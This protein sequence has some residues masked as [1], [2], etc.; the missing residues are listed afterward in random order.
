MKKY[1]FPIV[2][3]LFIAVIIQTCLREK[4][5]SPEVQFQAYC[6]SCH[7][8]PN[9]AN[10]PKAIWKNKVLPEMA[11]RLGYKYDNYNPYLKNSMEE[12]LF[13]RLS[14][15][16]PQQPLID[17]VK[18]LQIYDYVLSSAPDSIPKDSFRLSPT[19]ELT[20]FKPAA[21]SLNEDKL[22]GITSI[23]YD[24]S[25]KQLF[26]GDAY[27]ILHEWQG[28]SPINKK[29][30]SPIVSYLQTADYTYLT[31]IGYMNPSEKPLGSL[32]RIRAEVIDT[33]AK[34]LHRPVYTEITDLNEDGKEEVII[35]EFGNL[36]GQLSLLMQKDSL[37][38]K[39]TL[40]PLP[41]TIKVAIAD[42]NNDGAKDIIV[43]AA[44]GKEGIYILYQEEE[45]RFSIEQ[46]IQMGPE[47]GSSWFEL[48]D[49][50]K[51]G[52]LDIVLVNGDNADFS[53]F[54]KPYHGVRLFL[55][56]TKNNFIQK[57]FYPIH[58]AT[59]V[60][61]EDFDM[62]GDL[63]FAILSF[64]PDFDNA[65][66]QSFVLLDN[67]DAENYL[68]ESSI[69]PE[70][71]EGRWMVMEKGDFDQDGDVDIML[72]AFFLPIDKKH[73]LVSDQWRKKKSDLLFLENTTLPL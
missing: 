73:K 71:K 66:E 3:I 11:A 10:I 41:G 31:E 35:C 40:L 43:L 47:Y 65:P 24:H 17:S 60:L 2:L 27:G 70:A 26:I 22:A 45:L 63:D 56:D 19:T 50:N 18:W 58:G 34:N 1:G 13:I 59:R 53:N 67:K 46:V 4:Q 51:D 21:V 15:T 39:K 42:M 48:I 14:N 23:Q 33:L 72:G 30:N 7:L 44:Q 64:F 5:M 9:P 55:N 68:F 25:S 20:L 49:Y 36:S 32:Y 16:Y 38:E 29:F 37:F 52:Y 57:W 6:G 12:N 54:L 61:A 69:A 8:V 62:D 28:S